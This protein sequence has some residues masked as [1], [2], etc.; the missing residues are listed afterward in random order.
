MTALRRLSYVALVVAF[1]QIV[2][3]AIVRISG[4]GMGCG[5]HWPQCNGQWFP[6]YDR[7][8]LI[9][10]ITHRHLAAAL[11]TVIVVLLVMAFVRR[12]EP[13]VGGR[14]GVLRPMIVAAGLVVTAAVFGAVTVKLSLNPYVIVVHLSIAMALIAVLAL[15]SIRTGGLMARRLS[16]G[17][18]PASARTARSAAAAVGLAF[19]TLVLGALTA[20]VAGA[21]NSCQGFP[22]CTTIAVHGAPLALQVVHRIV[23]FLLLFHVFGM[24]MATRRRGQAVLT[25]AATLAFS[26]VVLQI[27]VAA[28]L[29]E[30]HL[31]AVWRS[32]HQA[33]GTLV[34]LTVFTLAVLARYAA[35]GV[36]R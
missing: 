3:G 17:A 12:R 8:D 33:T 18:D 28:T 2:F 4:S 9:I 10:E 20:N 26:V 36:P 15:V 25:T 1:A 14:G 11:T 35:R 34:W 13:G 24:F 22:W 30:L 16:G 5:D 29:V 7:T 23:A 21:N 27:L 31:P 6:P 19:L 32:I